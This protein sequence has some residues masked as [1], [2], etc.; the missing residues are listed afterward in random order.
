M[1]M[2]LWFENLS[3][4]FAHSLVAVCDCCWCRRRHRRRCVSENFYENLRN[5]N[6]RTFVRFVFRMLMI[7][8]VCCMMLEYAYPAYI[9]CMYVWCVRLH[10]FV[11]VFYLLYGVWIV[12]VC[13]DCV[14]MFASVFSLYCLI[15]TRDSPL[16][17]QQQQQLFYSS[18][19][20]ERY[21][22]GF[23]QKR[24]WCVLLFYTL[25]LLLCHMYLKR[26][27]KAKIIHRTC[28]QSFI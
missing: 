23:M 18:T 15:A 3:I 11:C 6:F 19:L 22:N 28:I 25:F 17:Q 12:C 27:T 5:W 1:W 20:V 13:V 2:C 16:P 21:L 26:N 9:E 4:Y 8:D 7:S 14:C 24:F 10:T